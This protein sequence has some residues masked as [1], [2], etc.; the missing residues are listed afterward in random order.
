MPAEQETPRV[1][2][3]L[4]GAPSMG[5]WRDCPHCHGTDFVM[6]DYWQQ[7]GTWKLVVST[8][9]NDCRNRNRVEK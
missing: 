8:P 1:A 7:D 4:T 6:S 9:C 2:I 5:V 3:T